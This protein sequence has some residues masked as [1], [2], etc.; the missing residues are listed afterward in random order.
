MTRDKR[1]GVTLYLSVAIIA[2]LASASWYIGGYQFG[3]IVCGCM[4]VS[5]ALDLIGEVVEEVDDPARGA[6]VVSINKN[7]D[8]D[9]GES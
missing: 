8:D 1:I 6:P 5:A 2:A 3:A 9:D 4:A 7:G